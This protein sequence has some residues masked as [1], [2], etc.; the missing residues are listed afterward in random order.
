MMATKTLKS[1]ILTWKSFAKLAKGLLSICFFLLITGVTDSRGSQEQETYLAMN[2]LT[3]LSLE[4]LMNIEITSVSKKSQKLSE[5]AAAVF[6][7]T[8]EDIRRSGATSIPEALRMVPGVQVAKIDTNKWAI[9]ARGFNGRLAN[10]LLV[11]MDGRS[12]YTPLW[13]GVF[14]ENIDTVLEDIDRIEVIRGPGASLWGANAV[15]GVINIITKQASETQGV[16]AS[17]TVGTEERGLAS[18]R[19]GGHLTEKTPF[20]VY[21]KG[22]ERDEAVFANGDD[23][24][25]DWRYVRG[26]F[27]LDHQASDRDQVTLQ[28]DIY[29][30]TT[31]ETITFPTFT[32]PYSVTTDDEN[33]HQGYNLL[34][35]WTRTFSGTSEMTLQT[36]YDR[37]EH[38]LT[39]IDAKVDTFDLDFQHRFALGDFQEILWGLG[40]R[41]VHD[42]IENNPVSFYAIDPS[43]RNLSTFS[44]FLQDNLTFFEKR[45]RITLGSK[46]EYNEYTHFEVQPTARVLWAP[47]EK[48][49]LW[50]SVSRAVRTPSRGERDAQSVVAVFPPDTV[51]P[52]PLPVGATFFGSN[53]YDSEKLVAYE[54]GYRLQATETLS[55]DATAYFNDYDKARHI[56][57]GLPFPEATPLPPHLILPLPLMNG[58][59]GEIYGFE[60]AADWRPTTWGRIQAAYTYMETKVYEDVSDLKRSFVPE[61]PYY[62]IS[63]RGSVNLPK[64]FELD[65][66]YRYMDNV[67]DFV[68]S[69]HNLDARLG[70]KYNPHLELSIVGQNLLDSQHPEFSAD[71]IQTARTEV[72]RSVYAKMTWR[73]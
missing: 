19:Y 3:R 49:S 52:G 15:N 70:W 67:G 71:F 64:N 22:F 72:E 37:S 56:E 63:L 27:R 43:S 24:A 69:Y 20:R 62:F 60:L 53:D 28:G 4:D 46:F 5:A 13:S 26:G 17:G 6:V 12:V 42:D 34:G 45:L 7:V 1:K 9:T 30:G 61:N 18:L 68:E 10:K 33:D 47:D 21:L 11:L 57:E 35:R 51:I 38:D 55:L 39:I 29:D 40:Y 66:W 31:G 58:E 73:F 54:L 8:Q 25:D 50:A 65:L 59:Q 23:A 48:H 32:P 36:Y 14:W 2:D 44:A 16:L 41:F